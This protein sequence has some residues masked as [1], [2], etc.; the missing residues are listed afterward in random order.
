MSYK[1]HAS[2]LQSGQSIKLSFV[3]IYGIKV[4]YN[5]AQTVPSLGRFNGISH[6]VVL[7]NSVSCS[8]PW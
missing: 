2:S 1:Q 5:L 3:L 8:V 7:K 6:G 4:R